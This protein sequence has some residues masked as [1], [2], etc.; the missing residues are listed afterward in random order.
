MKTKLLA[1]MSVVI[2]WTAVP[3][4]AEGAKT[5]TSSGQILPDERWSNVRIYNDDTVVDMLG[6]HVDKMA[7]YDYSIL[8]VIDG[9]ISTLNAHEFST[10]NVS[11]GYVCGLDAC[12][13]STV[14][15][16]DAA[17]ALS[18]VAC[19]SGTVN[20]TNGTTEY[21]RAGDSG[22]INLYGGLVTNCLDAWDS[23]TINT[24][25]YGFNYD[26]IAGSWDGGQ[27]RGFWLDDTRFTIDLYGI[28]TYS[29]INLIPEPSTLLFFALG[30]VALR[31][32]R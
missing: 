29:H 11:G 31:R 7:T 32:K 8:N 3:V 5:F 16:S 27:L 26:P 10:A 2:L 13:N 1:M 17:A 4:Y 19:D 12:G 25:G 9:D 14:G 18:L 23:A 30:F 20:M 15:F 21:L 6:G 22:I 24:Y 28:E